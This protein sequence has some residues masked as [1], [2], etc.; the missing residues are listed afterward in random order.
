MKVAVIVIVI[1]VVVDCN[2]ALS[3]RFTNERLIQKMCLLVKQL[4]NMSECPRNK[5]LFLHYSPYYVKY[6]CILMV[7]FK[8]KT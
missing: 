5:V 3:I 4:C 6:V 2:T 7:P 1:A 8:G